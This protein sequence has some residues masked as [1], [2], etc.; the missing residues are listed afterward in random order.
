MSF[1]NVLMLIA[2]A[3]LCAAG[4]AHAF[5]RSRDAETGVCLFLNNSTATYYIN[6]HCSSDVT[7]INECISAVR[8]AFDSWNSEACTDLAM[9]YGGTTAST[10]VGFDEDHWNENIN[11]VIFQENSW[12]HESS[13]IALTTTTYDVDSG[14]IVDFD[15]ECNG[16]N[17]DFTTLASQTSRMDIQNTIS[18]EVG[19]ALGLDHSRDPTATMY[20]SAAAGE[21]SKRTLAQDDIDALCFVYPVDGEIPCYTDDSFMLECRGKVGDDNGCNCNS[22]PGSSRGLGFFSW[23]LLA[24][25]GFMLLRRRYKKERRS[26]K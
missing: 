25:A 11:L 9:I 17:F 8:S 3:M 18:H 10:E 16:V 14:E 5:K 2:A 1:R 7:N 24:S 20:L 22:Y 13:A 4:P 26:E 23:L 6:E 21:I 12:S 19:H 15:I